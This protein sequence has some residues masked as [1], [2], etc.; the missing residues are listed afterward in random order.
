MEDINKSFLRSLFEYCATIGTYKNILHS[1]SAGGGGGG[2]HVN[3]LLIF[4]TI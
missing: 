1:N 2:C 4:W 3:L